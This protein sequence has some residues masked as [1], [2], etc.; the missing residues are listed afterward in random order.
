MF[1]LLRCFLFSAIVLI[2]D[3]VSIFADGTLQ[4]PPRGRIKFLQANAPRPPGAVE[5]FKVRNL[6]F[7]NRLFLSNDAR[8]LA[9]PGD[10][11]T[12]VYDLRSGRPL[13]AIDAHLKR[14]VAI[15]FSPDGQ[16]FASGAGPGDDVHIWRVVRDDKW[17]PE[18][19]KFDDC[20]YT[21]SLALDSERHLLSVGDSDYHVKI[22]DTRDGK[23]LIQF[24]PLADAAVAMAFSPDGKTLACV[25]FSDNVVHL[26][27]AS[28]GK[29]TETLWCLPFSF[30]DAGIVP[31]AL[32]CLAFSHDGKIL[33]AGGSD[34]QIH[35]WDRSTGAEL[36]PLRGHR[37]AVLTVAF[38]ADDRRHTSI[39]SDGQGL[40]WNA[41]RSTHFSAPAK[42]ENKQLEDYWTDLFTEDSTRFDRAPWG[43]ASRPEEC[44]RFLDKRLQPAESVSL[45][46]LRGLL[47]DVYGPH[48]R[49]AGPD[50][51][52]EC[53]RE[54]AG[55]IGADAFG[56]DRP[57]HHPGGLSAAR[58]QMRALR[59]VSVLE[60]IGSADAMKKL[61]HLAHGEPL[62][63]LTMRAQSAL[64]RLAMRR[65]V[66]K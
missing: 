59:A 53:W 11:G 24:G 52:P 26:R 28:T 18:L 66:S 23:V 60:Q 1:P 33:A 7:G 25:E 32:Q 44:V 63:M 15:A 20:P 42:A 34:H 19:R 55:S 12:V 14:D 56:R 36:P 21:R 2:V 31:N 9:I 3:R 10:L 46:N 47:R 54:M 30:S 16:S 64:N 39:A 50:H 4:D 6:I 57:R 43:L 41:E 62:R 5:S 45:A 27:D 22:L 37:A 48:W 38:S 29:E 51:S 8:T 40:V 35:F 58:D 49:G 13:G 61:Q 17:C 65:P